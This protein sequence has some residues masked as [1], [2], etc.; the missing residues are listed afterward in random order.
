MDTMSVARSPA[1]E[2]ALRCVSGTRPVTPV[3]RYAFAPVTGALE[4]GGDNAR[5]LLTTTGA[6]NTVT[7]CLKLA[8]GGA[9][10]QRS[11]YSAAS[12]AE[13]PIVPERKVAGA[14]MYKVPL[15]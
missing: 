6:V 15:T 7:S 10:S 1:P 11:W 14:R 4:N 8:L 2:P 3:I 12:G 9:D 13:S 5:R